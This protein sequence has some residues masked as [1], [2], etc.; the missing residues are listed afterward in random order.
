VHDGEECVHLLEGELLIYIADDEYHLEEG[1]S[2][3]YDPTEPHWY[4]NPFARPG[5]ILSAVTPPSF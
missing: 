5:I 1:D 2:I 4:R 3:T